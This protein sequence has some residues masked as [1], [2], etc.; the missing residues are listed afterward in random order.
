MFTRV[1]TKCKRAIWLSV[2]DGHYEMNLI[3][4]HYC[5]LHSHYFSFSV[6]SFDYLERL[7]PWLIQAFISSLQQWSGCK[8]PSQILMQKSV[9]DFKDHKRQT[10]VSKYQAVWIAFPKFIFNKN[11]FHYHVYHPL[12]VHIFQQALWQGDMSLLMWGSASDP[13]GCVCLWSQRG[14]SSWGVYFWSWGCIPACTG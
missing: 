8:L 9:F 5:W 14:V 1:I 2:W 7:R 12:V 4:F 11:A 3:T 6:V 13:V 10:Y